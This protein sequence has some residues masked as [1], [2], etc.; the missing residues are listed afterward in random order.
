MKQAKK[1]PKQ[2][3]KAEK[4]A[5][6]K[7]MV[8]MVGATVR[9]ISSDMMPQGTIGQVL[10]QRVPM[11]DWIIVYVDFGEYGEHWVTAQKVVVV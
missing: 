3:P 5:G 1:Q 2:Q 7:P 11:R 9:W 10:D 6:C 4:A 8:N